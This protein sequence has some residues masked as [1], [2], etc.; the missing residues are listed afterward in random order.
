MDQDAPPCPRDAGP[1]VVLGHSELTLYVRPSTDEA[2]R[3]EVV[4]LWYR[5]RLREEVAPMNEKWCAV[6][7]VAI[8]CVFVQRMKTRWGSCNPHAAII[9]LHSE[10]AKKPP[11]CMEYVRSTCWSRPTT[12]ASGG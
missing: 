3:E 12:T 4:A 11:E 6:M 5:D 7:G 10:L 9:R 8:P 2:R 1:E